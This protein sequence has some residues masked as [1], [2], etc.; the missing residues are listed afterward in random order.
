M[1]SVSK[2]SENYFKILILIL[3]IAPSYERL[4]QNLANNNGERM[5]SESQILFNNNNNKFQEA[6]GNFNNM[7]NMPIQANSRSQNLKP[8]PTYSQ[9]S[10]S[11]ALLSQAFYDQNQKQLKRTQTPP[12]NLNFKLS[13]MDIQNNVHQVPYQM[14]QQVFGKSPATNNLS[15][16]T[17][18]INNNSLSQ[19]LSE[20]IQPPPYS[21]INTYEPNRHHLEYLKYDNN[22]I[23]G[24][25][26]EK[27]ISSTT[28]PS[29]TTIFPYQT[30]DHVSN[31]FNYTNSLNPNTN[32]STYYSPLSTPIKNNFNLYSLIDPQ[33]KR[34]TQPYQQ[35]L[36]N[37][38]QS[39]VDNNQNQKLL[40]NSMNI[41]S[42]GSHKTPSGNIQARSKSLD[43]DKFLNLDNG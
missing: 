7:K 2:K 13:S 4:T 26:M 24:N 33:N 32:S 23:M 14:N 38:V 42:Y 9:L 12:K 36:L 3:A 43:A 6:G 37:Q 16:S 41:T 29:S 40:N 21:L 5:K 35:Q 30:T 28:P 20:S 18:N 27:H 19:E 8:L 10:M 34:I 15:F 39:P 22:W 11:N 17:H 25:T 1:R 31:P